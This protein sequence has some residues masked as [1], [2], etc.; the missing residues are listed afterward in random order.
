MILDAEFQEDF[1]ST[2][3]DHGIQNQRQKAGISNPKLHPSWFLH[4]IVVDFE[5]SQSTLCCYAELNGLKLRLSLMLH[6]QLK[7]LN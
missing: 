1:L 4:R 7:L 2:C 3:L 6:E 5:F